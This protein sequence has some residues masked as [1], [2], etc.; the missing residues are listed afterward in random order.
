VNEG[1]FEKV[2]WG[3]WDAEYEPKSDDPPNETSASEDVGEW[4]FHRT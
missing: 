2:G 1:D 4:P 3:D